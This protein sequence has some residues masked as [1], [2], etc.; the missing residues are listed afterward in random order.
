MDTKPI[1]ELWAQARKLL[2]EEL[3]EDDWSLFTSQLDPSSPGD[4]ID[5]LKR[6]KDQAQNEHTTHSLTIKGKKIFE[7]NVSRIVQRFQILSQMVD[8][9]ITFAPEPAQIVWTTL[10]FLT[11]FF[12]Q[13]EQL[14]TLVTATFEKIS[15]AIFFCDIYASRLSK[16]ASVITK[17]VM[18]KIPPVYMAVLQFSV[19]TRKLFP[20]ENKHRHWDTTIRSIKG[21]F[22]KTG[23]L[24]TLANKVDSGLQELRE[25]AG[26]SSQVLVEDG[27]GET[28]L[29]VKEMTELLLSEKE[30]LSEERSKARDEREK[31]VLDEKYSKRLKWLQ[32]GTVLD[33]SQPRHQQT[34]NINERTPDTCQWIFDH[35]DY[36]AW[37]SASAPEKRIL[38]LRGPAGAGKSILSSSIIEKMSTQ[39]AGVERPLVVYFFCKVGNDAKQNGQKIMHHLLLQ[40]FER[41][42]DVN[43][44]NESSTIDEGN[45]KKTC[46]DIVQARAKMEDSGQADNLKISTTASM[47]S[48]IAGSLTRKVFI[49]LDA[50]DECID[51]SA[52]ESRLLQSLIDITSTNSNV[53]L[54]ISSRADADIER[55]FSIHA[56]RIHVDKST[57]KKDIRKL[58][59]HKLGQECFRPITREDKKTAKKKI[60][61]KSE[62]M[63]Q[64]AVVALQSLNSGESIAN[65]SRALDR[66]PRGM[67]QLYA[68]KYQSLEDG[69]RSN[70]CII[71]R[72]LVCAEGAIQA[73][74]IVDE[75]GEIYNDRD[76]PKESHVNG[77][78]DYDESDQSDEFHESEEEASN[79]NSGN[80]DA[81]QTADVAATSM[82]LLIKDFRDFVKFDSHTNVVS[83]HHKSI[84][85]WIIEDAKCPKVVSDCHVCRERD[86]EDSGK[87][88][89]IAPKHGHLHMACNILR[90]LNNPVFQEDYAKDR[91]YMEGEGL[92]YELSHWT[93]HVRTAE[94]Y[95]PEQERRNEDVAA[96]WTQLYKA[97]EDFMSSKIFP[98]WSG[99][100]PLHFA[101]QEGLLGTLRRLVDKGGNL[102]NL[103]ANGRN[104][105]HMVCAGRG[106]YIG[107]EYLL[108]RMDPRHINLQQ[109]STRETPLHTLI[110]DRQ[111]AVRVT[112]HVQLLLEHGADPDLG[113]GYGTC[114][115]QAVRQMDLELC[116]TLLATKE[117]DVD[118]PDIPKSSS[119]L[120]ALHYAQSTEVAQLL[121]DHGAD[122]QFRN[123]DNQ[124]LLLTAAITGNVQLARFS[125]D[126]DADV[127]VKLRSS[128][129]T[130]LH[131]AVM[132]GNL[133]ITQ[134]LVNH[135][136]DILATNHE[137]KNPIHVAS[138][139]DSKAIL[140]YLLEQQKVRS[141]DTRFVL[142]ADR[143]RRTA[144]HEAS[145]AGHV[146]NVQLLLEFGQPDVLC[147]QKD[148]NGQTPL[149]VA[150]R[151]GHEDVI[152]LLVQSDARLDCVDDFGQTPLGLTIGEWNLSMGDLK[153]SHERILLFLLPLSPKIIQEV[154]LLELA[155][156]KGAGS[157][158]RHLITTSL[159]NEPDAHGWTPLLL[160]VQQQEQHIVDTL[161]QFDTSGVLERLSG[162]EDAGIGYPPTG[163][164]PKY[165]NESIAISGDGL[166]LDLVGNDDTYFWGDGSAFADHPIPAGISRYYY[167]V[168]FQDAPQS[169]RSY[170]AATNTIHP[171]PGSRTRKLLP[172]ASAAIG[173]CSQFSSLEHWLPEVENKAFSQWVYYWDRG[174][175]QFGTNVSDHFEGQEGFGHG[176]VVGAGIDFC[177]R[178]VFFTKNGKRLEGEFHGDQVKGRLFPV[179]GMNGFKVRVNFGAEPF[180][181][182]WLP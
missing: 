132:D 75:I 7:I 142:L 149:H 80:S 56:C 118:K 44:T 74:P 158:C 100:H 69:P 79:E 139:L 13:D 83:L 72:W 146:G 121:I 64:Y 128:G 10:K 14:C 165:D 35:N 6:V 24:H 16:T 130:A 70:L 59:D 2:Q 116:R 18:E 103:D 137:E 78:D 52:A 124:D 65:F 86:L 168:V 68:R 114:L 8:S 96:K 50:L 25:I 131:E 102:G 101:A 73:A 176:D 89:H 67:N 21:V 31:K 23:E 87:T 141:D 11:Q 126:R 136:A 170:I 169:R 45:I 113:G 164:D 154:E 161:S 58:L 117:L 156:E 178:T 29:K 138:T 133:T 53:S 125:L 148:D 108:E 34:E 76:K 159:A 157:I 48:D 93:F 47:F 4:V 42:G 94:Q 60:L 127:N 122:I 61:A 38:W 15:D 90:T 107:L 97:I 55:A 71:L 33:V 81:N 5:S 129:R 3:G 120:S 77:L 49:I 123:E 82:K 85:D 163:I 173:F 57:N 43:S 104:L 115:L 167:E 9:T 111:G 88:L 41:I 99:Q 1:P 143:T 19:E 181:Y 177:E 91:I 180:K 182:N 153:E 27:V 172:P 26:L 46:V 119:G 166:T 39:S 162:R 20:Q 109:Q 135:C 32:S 134:L 84:R 144:L 110:R 145:G 98:K 66:L 51:W 95:W 105:L 151:E 12:L 171:R 175:Y 54:F 63:F 152:R 28:N 40:L 147:S 30:I 62:G 174:R 179:I 155:I 17:K 106:N 92:R 150:A 22:G 112:N 37:V 36:Q 160:A 140:G